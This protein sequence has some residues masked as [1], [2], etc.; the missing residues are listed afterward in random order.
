MGVGAQIGPHDQAGRLEGNTGPIYSN[1]V[2]EGRYKPPAVSL[3]HLRQQQAALAAARAHRRAHAGLP[4]SASA[5]VL[6]EARSWAADP[7]THPMSRFYFD[8]KPLPGT[9]TGLE[10]EPVLASRSPPIADG[11][12]RSPPR[13][14][15]PPRGKSPPR[16][17]SPPRELHSPTHA[18][19]LRHSP[20]EPAARPEWAA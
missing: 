2:V 9:R 14:N 12:R 11:R 20:M 8:V 16:S 10:Y 5:P 1:A 13:S 17:R 15:S 3:S 6:K 7:R 18:F 4:T 19:S